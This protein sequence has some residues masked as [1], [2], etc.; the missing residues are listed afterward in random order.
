VVKCSSAPRPVDSTALPKATPGRRTCSSCSPQA[1]PP[2]NVPSPPTYPVPY[3]VPVPIPAPV[4][5]PALTR[6]YNRT[7]QYSPLSRPRGDIRMPILAKPVL[8]GVNT[9]LNSDRVSAFAILRLHHYLSRPKSKLA[10]PVSPSA[11][12]EVHREEK[13]SYCDT[14]A[15]Q[16]PR[17][18]TVPRT[19]PKIYLL[20]PYSNKKSGVDRTGAREGRQKSKKKSSPHG[21]IRVT[22][23]PTWLPSASAHQSVCI[24]GRPVRS[25]CGVSE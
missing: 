1:S 11:A 16:Q 20:S 14:S 24:G 7:V 22:A 13:A 3:P 25:R 5:V 9:G 6:T 15:V 2:T 19:P 17:L 4:P 12:T 21:N 8:V 23:E 18:A 10:Q